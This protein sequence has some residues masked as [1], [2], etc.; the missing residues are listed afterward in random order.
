MFARRRALRDAI[1]EGAPSD[2]AKYKE[3]VGQLLEI[4]RALSELKDLEVLYAEQ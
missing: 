3:M 4:E 2:Y 1:A